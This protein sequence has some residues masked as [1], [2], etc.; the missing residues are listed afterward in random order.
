MGIVR[1]NHTP[2][3]RLNPEPYDFRKAHPLFE[4]ESSG[5]WGLG[6]GRRGLSLGL[7]RV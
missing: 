1:D 2:I 5:G 6:N 3:T 7:Q 4:T